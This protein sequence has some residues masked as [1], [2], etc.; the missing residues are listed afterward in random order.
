MD[1]GFRKAILLLSDLVILYFSLWVAVWVGF[2]GQL[3]TT[4]YFSHAIPFTFLFGIWMVILYILDLYDLSVP[5]TS[6]AF[7][8]RWAL[9]LGLFL[10]SGVV[11]F[12]AVPSLGITPKTN[13]LVHVL[14]FGFLAY[15]ARRSF[16][17]HAAVW[18]I[19][20]LDLSQEESHEMSRIIHA[21]R[22]QGYTCVP[23]EGEGNDLPALIEKHHVHVVILPRSMFS[24]KERVAQMYQSLGTGV[25][26]L[27]LPAAYEM[28][29]RRVP[30][31]SIDERWFLQ[32]LQLPSQTS[33]ETLKRL[34]DLCGSFVL[35]VLSVPFWV[36]IAALIK[37]GDGGPVF[38]RQERVGQHRHLFSIMKFRTMRTDAEAQG[39]Q[40][41]SK[42]DARITRVGAFLR[43][44]HL[45]ELPQ[46]LNV[47][48]GDLSLVGPR[49]E[50]PEFVRQ[51]EVEIP[52]YRARHFIKPGFTGWAQ[53]KFRYARSVSDSK[54][55]FE[56]DLYYIKNRSLIMDALILLK[57][58]QLFFRGA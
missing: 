22:H 12:Y 6:A 7:L 55:K 8:R 41:A 50:R 28:F 45:D 1:L 25:E 56:Y 36:L 52:H 10:G 3:D 16:L 54:T 17:Q 9:A 38:Y 11:F 32:Y 4:L 26:F 35:L 24:N 39:A 57:T 46:M 37:V 15:L 44:T 19:G 29:A 33:F 34:V 31:D 2:W 23:L 47:L 18:R 27:D 30:V 49:P 58:I 43:R 20:L 51:L 53:I 48:K 14:L 21:Y 42:E 5:I 13:L 40:W